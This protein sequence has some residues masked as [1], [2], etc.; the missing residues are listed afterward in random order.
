MIATDHFYLSTPRPGYLAVSLRHGGEVR[1]AYEWPFDLLQ[2]PR[3]LRQWREA[4]D[5][6]AL[7]EMLRSHEFRRRPA[8]LRVDPVSPWLAIVPW[9]RALFDAGYGELKRLREYSLPPWRPRRRH[10]AL[11]SSGGN[12]APADLARLIG[13]LSEIAKSLLGS[14]VHLTQDPWHSAAVTATIPESERPERP[15]VME[16]SPGAPPINPIL[17]SFLAALPGPMDRIVI[18]AP[19]I[20]RGEDALLV[21][22]NSEGEDEF[23]G[24]EQSGLFAVYAGASAFMLICPGPREFPAARMFA[25]RLASAYPME[26][27]VATLKRGAG[28][29]TVFSTWLDT[30]TNHDFTTGFQNSYT[31]A[32]LAGS[33]HEDHLRWVQPAQRIFEQHAAPVF[34]H[35]VRTLPLEPS[36]FDRVAPAWQ[37]VL[38]GL[39]ECRSLFGAVVKSQTPPIPVEFE[40]SVFD[41]ES[42]LFGG[43][44][45]AER[46][47]EEEAQY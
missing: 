24:A 1:A 9:E 15:D 21:L 46:N 37:G 38:H 7:T 47:N 35:V 8:W 3:D 6:R 12:F 45:P 26:V 32:G 19:A 43:S 40:G 17:Q 13:R 11:L 29:A 34:E 31:L 44:E 16:A 10:T 2:L 33:T 14:F 18:L 41:L 22:K 4:H 23:V 30:E 28:P 5:L 20:L 25:H 39:A 42:D 27:R 36:S